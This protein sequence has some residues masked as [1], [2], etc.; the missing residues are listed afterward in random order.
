MIV[1][2]LRER[3]N[4]RRI[5]AALAAVLACPCMDLVSSSC[6]SMKSTGFDTSLAKM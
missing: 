4:R 6:R 3:A 1:L 5:Y 2:L